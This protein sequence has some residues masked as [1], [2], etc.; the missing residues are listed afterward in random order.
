LSCFRK[1]E[2][3]GVGGMI[4]RILRTAAAI[5]IAL[6]LFVALNLLGFILGVFP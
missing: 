6:G 1:R 5:V 3:K 4:K 2:E